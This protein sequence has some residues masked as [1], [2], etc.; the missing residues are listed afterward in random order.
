MS[1]ILI[2]PAS[3]GALVV[4]ASGAGAATLA[5]GSLALRFRSVIN[6]SLGFSAGAVIGVAVFDLFPEAVRLGRSG[7][8]LTDLAMALAAAVLGLLLYLILDRTLLGA[9]KDA[10][11]QTS[12][13][14]SG[15]RGLLGAASLTLH[16]LMDGLGIGLAFQ[17]SDAVGLT[18]AFAVLAHDLVDG[19]N[20][21]NFS[22]AGG[23]SRPGA[24]RWLAADAIA[25]L[26]G[27]AFS[28]LV[29]VP[30][31]GLAV[32]LALFSGFFL[33]IGLRELFGRGRIVT[34]RI[35][36]ASGA[37]LGLIWLVVRLAGG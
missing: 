22:L 10:S 28:R 19:V 2:N 6:L 20:T 23:V 3:L 5:G 7:H 18:V 35:L 31:G 13:Q 15:R 25:P 36:A 1:S 4:I 32:L 29:K 21:V 30:Q 26:I 24:R 8:A 14:A 34:P 12:A 11:A 27:I 16:S 9:R 33:Y 37:G 17:V